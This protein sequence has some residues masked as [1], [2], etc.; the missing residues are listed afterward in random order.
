MRY[1]RKKF[2]VKLHNPLFK[3]AI[4]RGLLPEPRDRRGHINT[5]ANL[6]QIGDCWLVTVPGELLPKLGLRIKDKLSA[7]GASVTGI[8]GLAN[9]ELGY[10]LPKEDFR[11]P[12]NPLHPKDHYEET[13]SIGKE[14][15]PKLMEAVDDLLMINEKEETQE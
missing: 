6:L 8:L 12:L 15:G 9:D 13:M 2:S 5:E 7:A 4:R 1:V 14:I 3:I 10:I 11:Y